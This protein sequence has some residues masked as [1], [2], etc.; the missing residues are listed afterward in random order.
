[1]PQTEMGADR[2]LV[3]NSDSVMH[4]VELGVRLIYFN[5]I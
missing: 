5:L 1:M 2:I 4:A 3:W